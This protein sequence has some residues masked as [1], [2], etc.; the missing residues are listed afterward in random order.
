[1]IIAIMEQTY[2]R[3]SEARERSA[4]L[5]RTH[6]YADFLWSMTLTNA[7][8]EKRYLYVVQP[9]EQLDGQEKEYK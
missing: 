8:K 6:F 4:L 7:F 9:V 2:E 1:M 5:E 3:V